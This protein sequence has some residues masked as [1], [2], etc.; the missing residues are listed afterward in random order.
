[1]KIAEVK[2]ER[3][4]QYGLVA[5]AVGAHFSVAN[6][7]ALIQETVRAY[8]T[9]WYNE[10]VVGLPEIG[11]GRITPPATPG[12]GVELQP[13]LL[14]RPDAHVQVSSLGGA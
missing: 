5:L 9:D 6:K 3:V 12:L 2:T 11:G 10:I 7:N 13:G 1:M 4:E 8:Y 14:S